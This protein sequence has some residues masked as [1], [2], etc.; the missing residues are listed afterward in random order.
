MLMR[1]WD[2]SKSEDRDAVEERKK[3]Q[4]KAL[5]LQ[6]LE[7]QI[8]AVQKQIQQLEEQLEELNI[9]KQSIED[10]KKAKKG[11]ETLSMISP[12]IFIKTSLLDNEEVII[13][14]GANVA[15]KKKAEDAKKMIENQIEEIAAVQQ[16]LMVDIQK[17]SMTAERLE[18]E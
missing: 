9:T 12:G 6:V 1:C 3:I 5:K 13:N 14:V 4:E 16:Q 17:L 2:L 7:Q 15:V 10:L 11:A 18:R 8:I